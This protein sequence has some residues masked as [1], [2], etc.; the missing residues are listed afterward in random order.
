MR[1]LLP[2]IQ[3]HIFAF[4]PLF[5]SL[6]KMQVQ[7]DDNFVFD[8]GVLKKC[9]PLG[10][11]LDPAF[12]CQDVE[13]RNLNVT[14]SY[15]PEFALNLSLSS[16]LWESKF[17]QSPN[18]FQQLNLKPWDV[19]QGTP[20]CG[21]DS[22]Q[23]LNL[24]NPYLYV[25][26]FDGKLVSLGGKFE[27]T[28]DLGDYCIDFGYNPRLDESHHLL[29]EE[30]SFPLH[31]IALICNHCHSYVCLQRCC[32]HLQKG[33]YDE[34]GHFY[35][36]NSLHP[37]PPRPR[38]WNKSSRFVLVYQNI[39][40]CEINR[41]NK[42]GHVLDLRDHDFIL[43]KNGSIIIDN[44]P[45]H[46]HVPEEYC[47]VLQS[48]QD[49]NGAT[50]SNEYVRLCPKEDDYGHLF[51]VT[52]AYPICCSVSNLFLLLTFIIYC[53][54]PD[55]RKPL[56]GKII[57]AFILSL[58]FAY[59][60]ISAIAF[61]HLQFV[62]NPD[63]NK[64]YNLAC[65]V[66]G[67]LVLF[68]FLHT[69]AWMNVLSYDIFQKFS[70]L[71]RSSIA[72]RAHERAILYKYTCYATGVPAF[73]TS[74]TAIVEFFPQSYHGLRPGFGLRNCF[75]EKPLA[76][77]VFFHLHLVI[78]QS[79]NIIFF[80]LTIRNLYQTWKSSRRLDEQHW[81]SWDQIRIII[82][83][84]V[85]MGGT[86][87]SEFLCFLFSWIFGMDIVWKYFLFNDLINL[88]QGILI[89][90]ALICNRS[91]IGKL[92]ARFSCSKRGTTTNQGGFPLQNRPLSNSGMAHDNKT[93]DRYRSTGSQKNICQ[94]GND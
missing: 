91:V 59:L 35:C 82:K 27:P 92:K 31:P 11:Y 85:I 62:I 49:D 79:T 10:Q 57:M 72:K 9:C 78:M 22:F 20:N 5:A 48:A 18:Q 12:Q 17:G 68:F 84:F 24:D 83:L 53:I 47:L 6:F 56:F 55:L 69:F 40:Q 93:S 66:M 71:P 30:E 50:I 29:N 13:S 28:F 75:F 44:D 80:V 54:L 7:S 19:S 33:D 16:E 61:G 45:S 52:K 36:Q 58:F 23:V 34:D 32:H 70:T 73:V 43:H 76:S 42:D 4:F 89:F 94:G 38:H 15:L 8:P 88:S 46:L 64:D 14:P 74:I 67:F 41:Q 86:W 63:Y 26:T 60:C 37:S 90:L 65:K 39:D 3:R 77:F 1:L 87:L 25:I 21:E 81:K 51:V 2:S